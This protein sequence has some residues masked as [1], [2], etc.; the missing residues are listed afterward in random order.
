MAQRTEREKTDEQNNLRK[1][2]RQELEMAEAP[3]RK[4]KW[5]WSLMIVPL[6][7]MGWAN[8][9]LVAAALVIWGFV[10]VQGQDEEVIRFDVSLVTVSVAVKDRKGR[11]LLGLKSEDFLVT[12]ENTRVTPEF[13]DSEGPAS[14]VFVV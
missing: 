12:D 5:F 3:M 1:I 8:N 11:A 2:C 4:L 10:P 7:T 9:L 14:I 6:A 13:F